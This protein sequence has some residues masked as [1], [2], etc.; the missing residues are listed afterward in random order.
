LPWANRPED[1]EMATNS[2]PSH[3]A[4]MLGHATAAMTMDLYDRVDAGFV[5]AHS[6]VLAG[7]NLTG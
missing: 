1:T 4:R 5:A 6:R 7:F 3:P 2:S